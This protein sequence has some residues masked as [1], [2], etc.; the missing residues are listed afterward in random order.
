[1]KVR[2]KKIYSTDAEYLKT[3]QEEYEMIGFDTQLSRGTLIV[4]ALKRRGKKKK[5][6][7]EETH[8]STKREK[9]FERKS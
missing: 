8:R 7:D 2:N 1:M 5:R 3:I 6:E 4:F 9:K